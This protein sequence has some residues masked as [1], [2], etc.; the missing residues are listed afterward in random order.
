MIRYAQDIG[1]PTIGWIYFVVLIS[2]VSFN[3]M[4]LY[5]ASMSNA[6]VTVQ[7]NNVDADRIQQIEQQ[8]KDKKRRE[9]EERKKR[10]Q[11]RLLGQRFDEEDDDVASESDEEEG[12]D[13]VEYDKDGNRVEARRSF[14]DILFDVNTYWMVHKDHE[15]PLNALSLTLRNFTS[16]PQAPTPH[17]K[18]QIPDPE[19]KLRNPNPWDALL[20]V[21]LDST[22]RARV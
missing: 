1:N 5:V 20:R 6:Y 18:P 17:P 14:S 8:I 10:H 19:S 2:F 7:Q 13:G 16:Y 22:E 4:N 3:I 15:K 11:E 9:R 21:L 12:E